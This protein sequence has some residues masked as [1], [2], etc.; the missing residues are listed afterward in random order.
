MPYMVSVG[1]HESEEDSKFLS[2]KS[3]F[4]MPQN[5]DKTFYWSTAIAGVKYISISTERNAADYVPGGA[6]Y[7]WIEKTLKEVDRV[8]TPWVVMM[9]HRPMYSSDTSANAGP[10]QVSLE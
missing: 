3:R 8:K 6:H 9:G 4:M 1:N 10:L 7:L 2:F 5:G